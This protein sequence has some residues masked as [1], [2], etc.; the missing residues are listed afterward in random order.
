[1]VCKLQYAV[2][3]MA[4]KQQKQQLRW[5][6][7]NSCDAIVNRGDEYVQNAA[8]KTHPVILYSI[9]GAMYMQSRIKSKKERFDVWNCPSKLI[10]ISRRVGSWF[11]CVRLIAI[12]QA[13]KH[14]NMRKSNIA[15][16]WAP[17]WCQ[18]IWLFEFMV[19]ISMF[20]SILFLLH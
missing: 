4:G 10:E 13:S 7:L 14:R 17:Y 1:M 5:R 16:S 3:I 11:H 19:F 18:L 6:K 2:K 20:H 8:A 12:K 15:H 9:F